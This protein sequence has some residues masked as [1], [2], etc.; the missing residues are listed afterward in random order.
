MK[1]YS[2]ETC[3]SRHDYVLHVF[4]KHNTPASDRYQYDVFL[5]RQVTSSIYVQ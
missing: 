4:Y 5:N 3:I 1:T 2:I